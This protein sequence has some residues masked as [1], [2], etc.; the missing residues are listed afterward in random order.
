LAARHFWFII[1]RTAKAP[2]RRRPVSSTLGLTGRAVPHWPKIST[3]RLCLRPARLEDLSSIEVALSDS[4]FPSDLPLARMLRESSLSSWLKRMTPEPSKP[5]L[6][7]ITTIGEDTCIGTVALVE[8]R[9]PKTWWLS[10][11]LTPAEWNKGLASEAV[12][13]LLSSA[14]QREPYEKVVA[15]TARSNLPSIRLLERLGFSSASGASTGQAIPEDHVTMLRWLR[16][17]GA[18]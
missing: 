13:A 4:R 6:W 2:C 12:A 11:W 18:A 9:L 14:A 15:V 7:A 8:E 5:T 1:C 10:Y 17:P 3:L 16:E